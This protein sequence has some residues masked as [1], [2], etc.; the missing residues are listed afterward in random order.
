MLRLP[1][2][3]G[4]DLRLRSLNT[5]SLRLTTAVA[6]LVLPCALVAL[7][8]GG[9]NSKNVD[10]GL[11]SGNWQI[12]LQPSAPATS[13]PTE[14]G[15]LLQTGNSLT[16]EFVFA[17]LAQC[18][19][20]GSALGTLT[21]N[22]VEITLTQTG[23][24]VNLTGTA[25]SDGSTM[26]GTYAVLDSGCGNGTS[27]G[28]WSANPVKPVTGTY[29]ATFNS[30]SLGV[31]SFNVT[32][33]QGANTGASVATLSG[34]ATS[35]TAPCGNDLTI[36]GVVGGTSIVFNFLTSGGT[37]V[38]QFRGTTNTDAT[39]MS[40]TYDFLAQSSMASCPAGDAG[41]ITVVQQQ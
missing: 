39:T 9:G 22:N 36:A 12:G 21:G 35:S 4:E 37:A 3:P 11:L 33:T 13:T 18:T 31:Y 27:T 32:V 16:G 38:G 10:E 24:T 41:S 40:G 7:S 30:Y 19:G 17:G 1:N 5:R 23:Q 14:S 15:F 8:C 20:L 6:V 29:L 25:A 2:S 28:T 34:N 26:G